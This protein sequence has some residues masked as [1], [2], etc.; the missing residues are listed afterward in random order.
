MA[1]AREQQKEN[2]FQTL[3]TQKCRE[4]I[5][6]ANL[7]EENQQ[8]CKLRLLDHLTYADIAAEIGYDRSTIS[9]RLD[10][11]LNKILSVAKK[12]KINI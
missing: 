3:T 6:A 10:K 8:I 1:I 5:E 12:E 11:I 7:G 4:L 2:P 9:K